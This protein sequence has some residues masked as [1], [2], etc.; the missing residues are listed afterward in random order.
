MLNIPM[1]EPPL[2]RCRKEEIEEEEA[3]PNAVELSM[4]NCVTPETKDSLCVFWSLREQ[5]SVG[6]EV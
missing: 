2:G 1:S 5:G 4:V 3:R 6:V